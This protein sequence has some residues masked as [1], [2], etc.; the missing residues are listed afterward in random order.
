MWRDFVGQDFP[1]RRAFSVVCE[2]P[3]AVASVRS[4]PGHSRSAARTALTNTWRSEVM[5]TARQATYGQPSKEEQA[6]PTVLTLGI[7]R[8]V[9]VDEL[10]RHVSDP[11]SHRAKVCCRSKLSCGGPSADPDFDGRVPR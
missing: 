7:R 1:V 3:A 11:V 10:V 6:P 2:T 5:D 9:R 4:E 8:Q